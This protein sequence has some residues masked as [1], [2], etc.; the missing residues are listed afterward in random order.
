MITYKIEWNYF[1]SKE[2]YRTT[3]QEFTDENHFENFVKYCGKNE[4][5][6]KIINYERQYQERKEYS[7]NDMQQAYLYARKSED[8]FPEFIRKY[9]KKQI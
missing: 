6:R 5:Y 4:S 7:A 3:T 1:N 9:F 2:K 8:S